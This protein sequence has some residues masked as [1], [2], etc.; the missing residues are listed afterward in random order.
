MDAARYAH[1][2]ATVTGDTVDLLDLD[3]TRDWA[4]RTE[5][6]FGRID[7]LVHLV[8]GWR[9]TATFAETDLADWDLLRQAPDPHRPAHL[10]RL[11]GR[12]AA[13]RPRPLS[14]DQRGRAPASPPRA[15]PPTP[16]SKAA[17]E[18]WTL[19]LADAFRKAGGEDGPPA[20]AAILV[21]KALVHD[22]MR[23][24]RPEREVRGLHRR[25]GPGRGHR[26]RLGAARRGSERK[27]PVAD[28]EA[29]NPPKTDARRHHDPDVRGFASD[30]YAGAHPE[31]LA[32]LALA[33]GGHQVAYGEDDYTDAPPAG[34]PQPLRRHA[35]R[36]SRSS[37]APAPTSSRSR[38]S[39]TAGAR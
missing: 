10:A 21:V 9:G 27:P 3:A 38:R 11:R 26:R 24:E 15:T 22:A 7:G 37:T 23:A 14:A 13:Q 39:P 16:P 35:P 1:G 18:A 12:P 19:A 25:Q 30:N 31:V 33:N 2:G 4:D 28:P 34:H 29:V 17:A 32:A 20:A 6:E 8:G 36:P 5:K